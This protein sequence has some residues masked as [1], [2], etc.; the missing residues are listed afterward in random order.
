MLGAVF[1]DIVGSAYEWNN[2]K[3]KDFPLKTPHTRYTD[4]TVMTLA[5]AQWLMED[6][7]HTEEGLVRQMQRL[8][9]G[10][11]NAGYGGRFK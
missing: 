1:G 6:P 2:V 11:L 10:H 8:G 4:D 3:T 9:R 7:K 5:V